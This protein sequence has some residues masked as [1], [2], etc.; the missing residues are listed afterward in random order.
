MIRTLIALLFGAGF[1][2]VPTTPTTG[3]YAAPGRT[4]P[5]GTVVR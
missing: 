4:L 3:V 5:N 1:M 2:P